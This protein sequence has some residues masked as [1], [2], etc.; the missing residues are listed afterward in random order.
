[1]DHAIKCKKSSLVCI[2]YKDARNEAGQCGVV[3]SRKSHVAYKPNIFYG[4][5]VTATGI[6]NTQQGA[7]SRVFG[8]EAKGGVAIQSLWKRGET[9]I[10]DICVMDTDVKAYKGLSLRSVLKA[11]ARVEK[12]KYLKA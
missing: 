1:M 4:A 2:Q 7:G 6:N 10:L 9:C 12:A 11:A 8:D 3:A 5:N